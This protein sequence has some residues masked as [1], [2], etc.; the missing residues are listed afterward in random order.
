LNS[1]HVE[2]DTGK[3]FS[4]SYGCWAFVKQTEVVLVVKISVSTFWQFSKI[5]WSWC[6]VDWAKWVAAWLPEQFTAWR[7]WSDVLEYRTAFQWRHATGGPDVTRQ[8]RTSVKPASP[9][10]VYGGG[11]SLL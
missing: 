4:W 11:G 9:R 10:S 7:H 1:L 8:C 3:E 6:T 2:R 5:Y